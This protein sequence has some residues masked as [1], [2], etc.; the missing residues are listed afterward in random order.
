MIYSIK[1][2]EVSQVCWVSENE[3]FWNSEGKS[4]SG[5][6]FLSQNTWPSGVIVL[7]HTYP[8]KPLGE[9]KPTTRNHEAENP[10]Y[11]LVIRKLSKVWSYMTLNVLTETQCQ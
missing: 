5:R 1:V 4:V 9:I 10:L 6:E 2:M 8:H 11:D 7:T 3:Q